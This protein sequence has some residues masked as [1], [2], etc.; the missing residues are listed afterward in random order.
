M[1]PLLAP[2]RCF[3]DFY[4]HI[5]WFIC[6]SFYIFILGHI[7]NYKFNYHQ[8]IFICFSFFFCLLIFISSSLEVNILLKI[9]LIHL[10]RFSSQSQFLTR[11]FLRCQD[12]TWNN[13]IFINDNSL[14]KFRSRHAFS[15][16]KMILFIYVILLN[17]ISISHQNLFGVLDTLLM[18]IST[19]ICVLVYDHR[20]T[21]K[22]M[23]L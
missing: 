3:V 6:T 19:N 15:I 16:N 18:I 13:F 2:A 14:H 7:S 4:I 1:V 11:L 23:W 5:T 20:C 22:N 12:F 17:E 21:S 10:L 8:L 9:I